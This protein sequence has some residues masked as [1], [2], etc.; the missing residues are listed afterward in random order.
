MHDAY[1][2]I[3]P[4]CIEQSPTSVVDQLGPKKRNRVTQSSHINIA[5]IFI[6]TLFKFGAR[7]LQFV[8]FGVRLVT[9]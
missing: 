4:F 5:H 8:P 3:S 7:S 2:N 1:R 6:E 9:F